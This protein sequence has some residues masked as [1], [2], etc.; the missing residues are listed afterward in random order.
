MGSQTSTTAIPL[1]LADILNA[2]S[3]LR[4]SSFNSSARKDA[5]SAQG[6][7]FSSPKMHIEGRFSRRNL[8][9]PKSSPPSVQHFRQQASGATEDSRLETGL[10]SDRRV[11]FHLISSRFG[12]V[13]EESGGS[14]V[15]ESLASSTL[16]SVEDRSGTEKKRAFRAAKREMY[17]LPRL[18][19]KSSASRKGPQ[20]SKQLKCS[21]ED[22]AYAFTITYHDPVAKKK[23]VRKK[24]ST[25]PPSSRPNS[26]S[27]SA[28]A[29]PSL[30]GSA[31]QQCFQEVMVDMGI[32][33]SVAAT[34]TCEEIS[35]ASPAN[36]LLPFRPQDACL[37]IHIHCEEAVAGTSAGERT[38]SGRDKM[39]SISAD[40]QVLHSLSKAPSPV[41]GPLSDRLGYQTSGYMPVDG[42]SDFASQGKQSAAPEVP[43]AQFR[44][45]KSS[46]T[47]AEVGTGPQRMSSWAV[48][49]AHICTPRG[50][51]AAFSTDLGKPVWPAAGPR[52]S[53]A[54]GS[55]PSE[56]FASARAAL[57][58]PTSS[59]EVD[60]MIDFPHSTD[61]TPLREASE[62]K[63]MPSSEGDGMGLHIPLLGPQGG[64]FAFTME[65]RGG[66]LM[67]RSSSGS[68]AVPAPLKAADAVRTSLQEEASELSPWDA[69]SVSSTDQEPSFEA[70]RMRKNSTTSPAD[71]HSPVIPPLP[72]LGDAQFVTHNAVS[73]PP[74]TASSRPAG[75]FLSTSAT[76]RMHY[77]YSL[78]VLNGKKAHPFAAAAASAL[79]SR[80]DEVLQAPG[81]RELIF[82]PH[83]CLSGRGESAVAGGAGSPSARRNSR[84][85]RSPA[86]P[87]PGKL[88]VTVSIKNTSAR[89]SST[90]EGRG[91]GCSPMLAARGGGAY[92]IPPSLS[93]V[94][95]SLGLPSLKVVEVRGDLIRQASP[96]AIWRVL[97]STSSRSDEVLTIRRAPTPSPRIRTPSYTPSS[98]HTSWSLPSAAA[99]HRSIHVLSQSGRLPLSSRHFSS[100]SHPNPS[101]ALK[102]GLGSVA[103]T[104]SASSTQG[105]SYRVLNGGSAGA[106]GSY[107]PLRINRPRT[108]SS[109]TA[110]TSLLKSYNAQGGV[111]TTPLPS[112][113][114]S[115]VATPLLF[116][117]DARNGGGAALTGHARTTSV[118]LSNYA[119]NYGAARG[120]DGVNRK[121]QLH[122]YVAESGNPPALAQG[123]AYSRR[124][125]SAIQQT[126]SQTFLP[127][128][129]N[130]VV[131]PENTRDHIEK[132]I[133]TLKNS[134]DS[135]NALS[136]ANCSDTQQE[137]TISMAEDRATRLRHSAPEAT[138]VLPWLFVGGE[139]PARD[140]AQLLQKGIT[141]IVNTVAYAVDAVF[142]TLF[143]YYLLY[144][145]DSPDEPIFSLFSLV[146][147]FIERHRRNGGKVFIHCHQGVSRSC[148]FVVA[149]LMWYHGLCYDR[150]YAWVRARRT[151]CSPNIGFF[152]MLR[153][154]ERELRRG[155]AR[156]SRA[157][158][159]APFR[160]PYYVPRSFQ[161]A[162]EFFSTEMEREAELR[163]DPDYPRLFGRLQSIFPGSPCYLDPRFPYG[164]LLYNAQKDEYQSCLL[165]PAA[166]PS[167]KLS[168][169]APLVEAWETYLNFSFFSSSPLSADTVV[170]SVDDH[171]E[172]IHYSPAPFICKS[173]LPPNNSLVKPS[174]SPTLLKTKVLT[175]VDALAPI[176]GAT[177][178]PP[179][180]WRA[181][182]F[183]HEDP[184]TG[185]WEGLTEEE[186]L[187]EFV[188]R[189]ESYEEALRLNATK[190]SEEKRRE[191]RRIRL[192]ELEAAA[193]EEEA[194]RLNPESH[195]TSLG[196]VVIP[197]IPP[198]SLLPNELNTRLKR[199]RVE[200]G[201]LYS[202]DGDEMSAVAS[203]EI[204][205]AELELEEAR[206]DAVVVPYPFAPCSESSTEEFLPLD[207][208]DPCTCYAVFVPGMPGR[209]VLWRGSQSESISEEKL[210]E[211]FIEYYLNRKTAMIDTL[212]EP[213]KCRR[214][215]ELQEM[216]GKVAIVL[217]GEE[218]DDLMLALD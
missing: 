138:E 66:S 100:S 51:S 184:A 209:W 133:N 115:G 77:H 173:S 71:P 46:G 89:R 141:G 20:M 21:S 18:Q 164:F 130:T 73:P 178:G 182:A 49:L 174:T 55:T 74:T 125:S 127:E 91:L 3:V 131:P 161:L 93:S 39:M 165:L 169:S 168:A 8:G 102:L 54:S 120:H 195:A 154:W 30:S 145:Q 158:A 216:A 134:R 48:A 203:A 201:L 109:G 50:L 45:A 64:E 155:P 193:D 37:V 170:E 215:R 160:S 23:N 33:P 86:P 43:E 24:K 128:L 2:P 99:T 63:V 61:R 210:R 10:E 206:E 143:D 159:L 28:S 135:S 13:G 106:S 97:P 188:Q 84:L 204:G 17:T 35:L 194:T 5:S 146:N 179:D 110:R 16:G 192:L 113:L 151:V 59:P 171:N 124:T 117:G 6:I 1:A 157:F 129:S 132:E 118:S 137:S 80:L 163:E 202:V 34:L 211:R 31:T 177:V 4:H 103:R 149:F 214:R 119:V 7:I 26:P 167:K 69:S 44:P 152:V 12:R 78:H 121:P 88:E 56:G 72:L 200:D 196:T 153:L 126:H 29:V 176:V 205:L 90:G 104:R 11:G 38:A 68:T 87:K 70:T 212:K 57:Y 172:A 41:S 98:Y 122:Y 217:E 185:R 213:S 190:E 22:T 67:R 136:V 14:V 101:L 189:V 47:A 116:T 9:S 52:L 15:G 94:R 180:A 162:M 95:S 175:S 53:V 114:Q 108:P 142:E 32:P 191:A 81:V 218:P 186:H 96:S 107:T 187:G 85:T 76:S 83:E 92:V 62:D 82:V 207:A 36:Q 111:S 65:D 123:N 40:S 25:N 60:F 197:N 198:A 147:A 166:P 75:S 183:H 156:R 105:V 140:E 27:F 150:A 42:L 58:D 144:L 148:S 181:S 208:F 79:A 19:S 112:S 199:D 139:L